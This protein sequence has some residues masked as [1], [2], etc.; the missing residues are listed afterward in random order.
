MVDPNPRYHN[1]DIIELDLAIPAKSTPNHDDPNTTSRIREILAMDLNDPIK[2]LRS[3]KPS[4][5]VKQRENQY[6]SVNDG[7]SSKSK[8]R[9]KKDKK[10]KRPESSRKSTRPTTAM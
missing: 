1:E 3:S 7:S 10:S 8:S 2:E 5:R 6:F 4:S 9:R